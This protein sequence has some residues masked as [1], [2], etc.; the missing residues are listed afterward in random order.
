MKKIILMMAFAL[1]GIGQNMAQEA[2]YTP[3]VRE[4]VQWVCYFEN[5][6]DFD[7]MG[8]Q[9]GRTFFTLELKGDTVIDGKAY[10]AMHKYSGNAIDPENDTVLVYLR[11]EN[12]IVYAIIPEGMASDSF[13]VGYG[14]LWDHI[15]ADAKAGKEIILYEFN[16]TESYYKYIFGDKQDELS[17]LGVDKVEVG[18]QQVNRHTFNYRERVFYFIEGIGYDGHIS[19]YPLSYLFALEGDNYFYLSH[20]VENGKT[21]YKSVNYR[22][23][24]PPDGRMPMAREGMQ[25]VFERVTID[26]GEAT[27]QYYTYELRG[28]DPRGIPSS[29]NYDPSFRRSILCRY[30]EGVKPDG[31]DGEIVASLKE[32]LSEEP[33]FIDNTVMEKV[34]AEGRNLIRRSFVIDNQELLYYFNHNNPESELP[35]YIRLQLSPKILTADNFTLVEPVEIDGYSCNRYAYVDEDGEVQCY[36]IEGIGI[37]SR[38][39]GDLLAPFTRKPDPEADYQEYCGLSHVIMDGKIIYKGMRYNAAIVEGNPY[40]VDGDGQVNI[41]DVTTLIDMLL[42]PK[43]IMQNQHDIDGSGQLNIADVTALIDHILNH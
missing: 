43:M 41:A 37:D 23:P 32:M 3:F 14:N 8:F 1:L 16:E 10:K 19:G 33:C 26:H 31:S 20:V 35:I 13:M 29:E 11:E 38:D 34:A 21:I 39:M 4:G 18:G 28:L 27:S 30:H 5:Y 24:G 17:Y 22:Q 9:P 36:I 12:R 40:D 15:Y 42:Q 6:K 2:D 25:W 7:V